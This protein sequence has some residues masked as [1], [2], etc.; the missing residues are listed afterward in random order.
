MPDSNGNIKG[1]RVPE[2]PWERQVVPVAHSRGFTAADAFN[3][4]TRFNPDG[5]EKYD[6]QGNRI[7]TEYVVSQSSPRWA[8][9]D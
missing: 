1:I 4:E 5:H 3:E 8:G 7:D 6:S 9:T 2:L